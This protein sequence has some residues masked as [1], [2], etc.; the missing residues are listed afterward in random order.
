MSSGDFRLRASS[1]R[2]ARACCERALFGQQVLRAHMDLPTD[3]AM[4]MVPAGRTGRTKSTYSTWKKMQRLEDGE[5]CGIERINDLVALRV[6]LSPENKAVDGSC[7]SSGGG[8]HRPRPLT[9]RR[10]RRRRCRRCC[11]RRRL[12]HR[13]SKGL[14]QRKRQW[15]GVVAR[16]AQALL[17][18]KPLS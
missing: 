6:V 15:Q 13:F 1:P 8:R 16:F 10:R 12:F 17:V 14:A 3:V 5:H 4:V 9:G 2:R 11:R 18:V 7:A